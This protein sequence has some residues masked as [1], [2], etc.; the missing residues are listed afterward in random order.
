MIETPNRRS[1]FRFAFSLRTMFVLVTLFACWLG[2]EVKFVQDRK[3]WMRANSAL[4]RPSEP[5]LVGATTGM[6]IY[7]EGTPG[8]VRFWRRWLGDA[9]VSSIVF[10]ESWINNNESH[11]RVKRLFPEAQLSQECTDLPVSNTL[12]R[13][14]LMSF[15]VYVMSRSDATRRQM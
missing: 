6:Y 10:P 1:W 11:D 15:S 2:Y 14:Y 7:S 8:S 4:I 12:L 5:T 3:A 13:H 9:P